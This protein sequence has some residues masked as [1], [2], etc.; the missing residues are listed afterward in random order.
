MSEENLTDIKFII[1]GK[2]ICGKAK[3]YTVLL[4]YRSK[5]NLFEL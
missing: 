4:K 2:T 3:Q 1:E 5:N